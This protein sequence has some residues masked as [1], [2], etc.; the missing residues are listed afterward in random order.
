VEP[1]NSTKSVAKEQAP[2]VNDPVESEPTVRALQNTSAPVEPA[3]AQ[4]MPDAARG[5]CASYVN[6]Q[7]FITCQSQCDGTLCALNCLQEHGDDSALYSTA[8]ACMSALGSPNRTEAEAYKVLCMEQEVALS[9]V[10]S[11]IQL[12]IQGTRELVSCSATNCDA[13]HSTFLSVIYGIPSCT[14]RCLEMAPEERMFPESP[15]L[16]ASLSCTLECFL[17]QQT[18]NNDNQ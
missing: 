8:F 1:T 3:P 15:M 12:F 10:P 7:D 18:F 5:A 2:I 14:T 11:F 4:T 6:Q 13:K 9:E 17:Q 16:G